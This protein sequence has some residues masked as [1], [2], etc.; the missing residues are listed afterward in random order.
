M[1][2]LSSFLGL[3][4]DS[5][6]LRAECSRESWVSHHAQLS[7]LRR[8]HFSVR[9]LYPKVPQPKLVGT[10]SRT[11]SPRP[12]AKRPSRVGPCQNSVIWCSVAVS[13]SLEELTFE[14]A[15]VQCQPGG[16]EET[17]DENGLPLVPK[18]ARA[19]FGRQHH[20]LRM[21]VDH[22]M[23][24]DRRSEE[25]LLERRYV[26]ALAAPWN[27]QT[28]MGTFFK[29]VEKR[30][31][32]L[33][34]DVEINGASVA[35]SNDCFVHGVQHHHRSQLLA[36]VMDRGRHSTALGPENVRGSIDVSRSSDSSHLRAP[37]EQCLHQSGKALQHKSPFSI[38]LIWKRLSSPCW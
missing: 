30:A 9:L 3:V 36:A 15:R 32:P 34:E 18:S 27:Y 17:S 20:R 28:T 12:D 21:L 31:L 14:V 10:L 22:F 5:I 6:W 25:S 2:P 11:K 26:R 7:R 16:K 33:V 23:C 19:V 37:S 29:F 4:N 8:F 38:I 35:Y 1:N 13:N 24:R